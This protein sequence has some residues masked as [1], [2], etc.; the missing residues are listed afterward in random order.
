ML[1]VLIAR[2]KHAHKRDRFRVALLALRGREKHE[3]AELL[4][5]AMSTV[6]HWDYAH[7]DDDI[8]ALVGKPRRGG[9]PKIHG[10]QARLPRQRIDEGP[11]ESDGVC[12][13]RGK[14]L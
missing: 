3:V 5:V 14:D 8:G 12:T 13:L 10:E 2:E 9:T 1:E 11:R 7:S 4:G 6:E